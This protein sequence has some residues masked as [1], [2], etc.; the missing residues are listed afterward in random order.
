M[1]DKPNPADRLKGMPPEFAA[2]LQQGKPA[3][4][5]GMNSP[6]EIV[7][8]QAGVNWAQHNAAKFPG[9]APAFGRAVMQVYLAAHAELADSARQ[10]PKP[11]QGARSFAQTKA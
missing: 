4:L 6:F 3:P 2:L 11:Q 5:M 9:D 10:Q 1:T 7:A 8:V